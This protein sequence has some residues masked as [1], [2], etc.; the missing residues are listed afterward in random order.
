M[1]GA[2][3]AGI[4]ESRSAGA[5]WLA[6]ADAAFGRGDVDALVAHLSAAIQA[7]TAADEPCRAAMAC[8]RLGETMAT[9][10]GNLTAAR[11]WFARACRLIEDQPPC[12]EQGWVAVAAMGCDVDDPKRLFE[13]AELALER[14]RRFGDVNLETKALADGGLAQVQAGRVREGMAML[15]EAMALA[16]GPAD[17]ADA[18]AKS[19]CSFFT[20]CYHAAD[21]ERAGSWARLLRRHGLI[22]HDPGPQVFLSSHCD[23]VQATALV[24]LG[25]WGDA[26]SMLE[27]SRASFA[28]AMPF[29]AWHPEI[30]LAELRGRQGRLA[31]AEELLLGRDQWIQALLPAARLHLERGDLTL[32]RAAGRRGLRAV[33]GDRLRAADLLAVLVDVELANGDVPAAAVAADE[34]RARVGDLPIPSLQARSVAARSRVMAAIGDAEGAVAAL[35]RAADALDPRQLPWL[36]FVLLVELARRR[37]AI[38]DAAGA[39]GDARAACLALTTLDVAVRA[40]DAELL[41]RLAPLRVPVGAAVTAAA[42]PSAVGVGDDASIA[43]LR[44]EGR[45]WEVSFG[46]TSVRL[47]DTK[48]LRYLADLVGRPGA[49]RH[50]LDLVDRVEGL[51]PGTDRRRLGDAGPAVDAAARAT[52]RHRIETLRSEIDDLLERGALEAAE[53]CQDE[54]DAL[55]AQLAAAFGLGG[56]GRPVASAAERARLNV[57]R[58]LR[59]AIS[60]VAEVLPEPAAVLDRGV[61][62]GTYCAYVPSGNDRIRWIVRSPLN[63]KRRN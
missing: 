6:E 50:A 46:G 32:A 49:E 21:F 20:A 37:E 15:D 12:V 59:A 53:R 39:A 35:E 33:G 40:D 63:E 57:T 44:S 13:A 45:W 4:E 29:P 38:G 5:R 25:R 61:R 52:Y 56:R 17:D 31:E 30:A 9:A 55:V 19:V 36:H 11:A 1:A 47:P 41:E 58:A 27:R 16:C 2:T 60:R 8:V 43:V 18:A 22:G 3:R 23:S 42:G 7:F 28:E 14:A 48:G 34:L 62:T 24:E 54:A 10:L 26:Q 51:A